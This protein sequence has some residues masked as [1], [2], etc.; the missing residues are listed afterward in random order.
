MVI[1][2]ALRQSA[3]V[4]VLATVIVT[5]IV[6][7]ARLRRGDLDGQRA[8]AAA[9]EPQGAVLDTILYYTALYYHMQYTIYRIPYT[10]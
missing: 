8:R 4:T 6:R 9:G 10:I 3:I 7:V 2:M 1:V 5:V